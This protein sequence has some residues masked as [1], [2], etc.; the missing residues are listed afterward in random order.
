MR[1]RSETRT[2][3]DHKLSGIN[4]AVCRTFQVHIPLTIT[5]KPDDMTAPIQS[6]HRP[7]QRAIP[8]KHNPK[9]VFNQAEL[10]H[11]LFHSE[12]DA[13][14]ANPTAIIIRE[15]T[16][17]VRLLHVKTRWSKLGLSDWHSEMENLLCARE[18]VYMGLNI[19]EPLDDFLDTYVFE[20]EMQPL[21]GAGARARKL[22]KE[23][24]L[25]QLHETAAKELRSCYKKLRVPFGDKVPQWT[26]FN[27]RPS[28]IREKIWVD[29]E[30]R[31]SLVMRAIIIGSE[32]REKHALACKRKMNGAFLRGGQQQFGQCKKLKR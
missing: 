2:G 12:Y 18:S 27:R 17:A 16:R 20:M 19:W 8:G 30:K 21:A 28:A 11:D 32:A 25:R 4:C 5:S 22:V 24:L 15:Y 14:D 9:I 26:Y 13:V 29:S 23:G 1:E 3:V 7:N 6:P 10:F 31:G